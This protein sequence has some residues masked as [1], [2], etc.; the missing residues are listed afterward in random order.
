MTQC[1]PSSV[2]YPFVHMMYECVD[3]LMVFTM[4][5]DHPRISSF[6]HVYL[7]HKIKRILALSMD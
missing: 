5:Y 7:E 2:P 3:L 1:L 4:W 6:V